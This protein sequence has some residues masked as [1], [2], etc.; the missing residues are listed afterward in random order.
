MYIQTW[1]ASMCV[2]YKRVRISHRNWLHASEMAKHP[3]LKH[4]NRWDTIGTHT[5]LMAKF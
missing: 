5:S 2:Q 1:G 4:P 3:S